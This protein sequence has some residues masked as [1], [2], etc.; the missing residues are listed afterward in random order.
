[1]FKTN[2]LKGNR[3]K[4]GGQKASLKSVL[5]IGTIHLVHMQNFEKK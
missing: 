2:L 4:W 3:K 5:Y 1:M